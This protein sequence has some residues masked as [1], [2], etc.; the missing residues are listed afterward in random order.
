MRD[1]GTT[2]VSPPTRG[3]HDTFAEH[4]PC[5]L[6][7]R[8]E[9]QPVEGAS[10]ATRPRRSP[11]STPSKARRCVI[12]RPSCTRYKREWRCR[13]HTQRPVSARDSLI[14]RIRTGTVTA[15]GRVTIDQP[16]PFPRI[17]ITTPGL[18]DRTVF[19]TKLAALGDDHENAADVLDGLP[20]RFDDAELA[21]QIARLAADA[22]TRRNTATTIAN[23]RGLAR[24]SYSIEFPSTTDLS[25][26]VLWPEAPAER[27]GMEDARFVGSSTTTR[28]EYYATY[29]AFDGIKSRAT[30]GTP[31]RHVY[32]RRRSLAPQDRQGTRV[33]PRRVH[34]RYS[35]CH[36]QIERPRIAFSMTSAAGPRGHI[37]VPIA[38]G[39]PPIGNCGS[40]IETEADG[41]Y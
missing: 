13:I 20:Q 38:S 9:C 5:D 21:G 15:A 10:T 22:A 25:E 32:T 19:H 1:V 6:R 35:R 29:T 17:G 11:M 24:S 41:S 23:L 14:D 37:Q 39:D 27:H 34:G 28:R 4:R 33:V 36:E 7:H 16:G 3:A 40:P 18:N 2:N 12:P 30:A 26:R 8:P 31:T